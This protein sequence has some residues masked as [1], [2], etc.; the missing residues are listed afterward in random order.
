MGAAAWSELLCSAGC[1]A[2][3]CGMPWK[4]GIEMASGMSDG[5]GRGSGSGSGSLLSAGSSLSC[6]VENGKVS[7]ISEGTLKHSDNFTRYDELRS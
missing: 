5:G 1:E 7:S 6:G 3:W 2:V 4:A